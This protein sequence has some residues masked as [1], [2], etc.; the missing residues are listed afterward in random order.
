M[1]PENMQ[2]LLAAVLHVTAHL[3]YMRWTSFF[4]TAFSA[5]SEGHKWYAFTVQAVRPHADAGVQFG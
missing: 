5:S 3:S 4:I 1:Q 2:L